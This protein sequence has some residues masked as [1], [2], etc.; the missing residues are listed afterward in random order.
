MKK[1]V[2]IVLTTL[3]I[4]FGGLFVRS[5]NAEEK[6]GLVGK[7][8]CSTC[9]DVVVKEFQKTSHE[10][11]AMGCEGCHGPGQAHVDGGG[12]KSKI[13]KFA[14]LSPVEINDI[15]LSC[16]NKGTQ[17]HW[18]GSTHNRRTL[19][20]IT[21][22]NPH[23]KGSNTPH[24]LRKTE[25]ELC[26]E[27]H[28][29]QKAQLYNSAHM[30]LREGK[31][32]C[33]SCHNPHGSVNPSM[34]TEHSV[35]ENCYKCHAEKRGPFLWEHAPVRINCD[36]CHDP[37]GSMHE[38]MLKVKMPILCQECH[39][40]SR[41]PSQAHMAPE[42]FSFNKSCLNCHSMIHGSNHPSGVRFMR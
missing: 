15:C 9:H 13:R 28:L 3:I 42:R 18:M 41:H 7:E 12:D 39:V 17:S 5:L 1:L 16:H 26:T 29:Q 10:Q 37:H 22:H 8:T 14:E 33:S 34:L 19:S 2:W 27:C 31:M 30:P 21:C 25:I 40:D 36:T 23:P 35:N 38:S 20:C 24:L 4:F 32:N 6:R 11:S